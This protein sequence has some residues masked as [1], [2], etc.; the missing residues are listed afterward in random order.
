MGTCVCACGAKYRFED[1]SSGRQTRCKR[2]GVALTL[3]MDPVEPPDGIPIPIIEIE[4]E[5]EVQS[6][7]HGPERGYGKAILWSFLFPASIH[8]LAAFLTLWVVFGLVD[9][10]PFGPFRLFYFLWFFWL[11]LYFWYVAFQVAVVETAAAGQFRLPDVE[12]SGDILPDLLGPVTRWIGSWIL[13]LAPAL[14]YAIVQGYRGFNV[15]GDTWKAITVPQLVGV[16]GPVL[17]PLLVTLSILGFFFWPLIL[18]VVVIGG[19]GELWRVDRVFHTLGSTIGPYLLT[20]LI[21]AVG[22]GTYIAEEVFLTPSLLS[23][24]RSGTGGGLA[25]G[26]ATRLL[27]TGIEIYVAIIVARAIG[28]YF[29]H[30]GHR[31]AWDWGQLRD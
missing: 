28:L 7:G 14:G 18:I 11:A 31:F 24:L 15:I 1:S 10:L 23:T 4:S 16:P 12:V 17:D 19:F 20:V 6:L 2:C 22:Y 8:N 21:A 13:V 3:G 5:P 30:F 9:F 25:Q 27:A 29:H 26:T